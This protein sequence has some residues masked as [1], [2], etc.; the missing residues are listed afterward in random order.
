VRSGRTEIERLK[1]IIAK[2]QRLQFGPRSEKIEREIEQLELQLEELQ[3]TNQ[4]A[5]AVI[6]ATQEKA[7]PAR[8][9]LP[10]HLPREE[11]V[12]EPAC[13]CPDCGAAMRKIG[14]D[15]SEVLEYVPER[16]KVIRHVRPKLACPACERIV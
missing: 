5:R 12:H 10:E 7:Q 6:V 3:V 13:E 8:R 4:A 14:E 1:L 15:V 11:H 16:F 2:L 9:A